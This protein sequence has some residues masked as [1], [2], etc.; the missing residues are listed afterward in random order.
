MNN[1]CPIC[2]RAD[3]VARLS[4]IYVAGIE[5]KYPQRVSKAGEPAFQIL[6]S[7]QPWKTLSKQDLIELS[8]RFSPPSSKRKNTT[9]LIHPDWIVLA[10]LVVSPIFLYGIYT[11][12]TAI[13]IPIFVMLIAC[14]LLYIW[15]R[16]SLISRFKTQEEERRQADLRIKTAVEHWMKLN[17]CLEDDVIFD[18]ERCEPIPADQ[19]NEIIFN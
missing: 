15:K 5:L 10:L 14:L 17:Y 13:F 16:R 11:T 1:N 2:G 7:H 3:T 12:Q 4:A 6:Q 9:R 19:L 18:P 8:K